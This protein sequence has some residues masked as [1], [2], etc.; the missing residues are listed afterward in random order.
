MTTPANN[1]ATGNATNKS[2]LNAPARA[3][4]RQKP[5]HW[6]E[7]IPF[8]A[9]ANPLIDQ[10]HADFL[11]IEAYFRTLLEETTAT[12]ED[13]FNKTFEPHE[14]FLFEAAT[15]PPELVQVQRENTV[16]YQRILESRFKEYE[17]SLALKLTLL[18]FGL[19]IAPL[20]PG[21][22]GVDL[23]LD[24]DFGAED[25]YIEMDPFQFLDEHTNRTY[26]DTKNRVTSTY[27]PRVRYKQELPSMKLRGGAQ[28]ADVGWEF[29]VDK[30]VA[31]RASGRRV[32]VWG[33]QGSVLTKPSSSLYLSFV[34]AVDLLL[35]V[36]QQLDYTICVEIWGVNDLDHPISRTNGMIYHGRIKS[37]E[38]D[39]IFNLLQKWFDDAESAE[40]HN[41]FVYFD[42]E[43]PPPFFQPPW[44]LDR[45]I[46]RVWN[47]VSQNMTYMKA[48]QTLDLTYKPNQYL[49]EYLRAMQVLF[50][51]A[52]HRYLQFT[53]EEE[54]GLSYG[55][56][57]PP[58]LVWD[59]VV[60]DQAENGELP[61]I[62]ISEIPLPTNCVAVW[63]PGCHTYSTEF[64]SQEP[65]KSESVFLLWRDLKP[66]GGLTSPDG[67][68][69]RPGLS[70]LLDLATAAN[71]SASSSR[72][73]VGLDV[74][75]P[76][77]RYL[78]IN[79]RPSRLNITNNEIDDQTLADWRLILH[80]F[81][82]PRI[83]TETKPLSIV[84][85]P[86]FDDYRFQARGATRRQFTMDINGVDATL[87][88][89]KAL[90]KST[91]YTEY[92]GNQKDQVL[93]LVQSTWKANL[94]EF[95]IRIDTSEEEWQAIVRRI[96]E[97]EITISLEHWTNEWVV[98]KETTWGPR[99]DLA[100]IDKLSSHYEH[101][102]KPKPF[103]GPMN[104]FFRRSDKNRD[105]AD[106]AKK[107]RDRFFWDIPSV[108]ANPAKP[109]IPIQGTPVETIIRTGPNV[110]G[111]ITAMRTPSE[112]A[113]LEREVHTLR[114]NLLQKI[115]ECP[116]MDCNRYFPF[117][118]GEGLARHMREEHQVLQCFLCSK[119][120]TL[121][122]YNS[123]GVRK[124]FLDEHYDDLKELF[125]IPR[126]SRPRATGTPYCNRC[127]RN[128]ATLK[129]AQD[130]KHHNQV[131]KVGPST[132][133]LYCMFCGDDR[134]FDEPCACGEVQRD[135]S[136]RGNFC[137]LCCLEYDSTMDLL[138]RENHRHHCKPPGGRLNDFCPDCGIILADISD[139]KKAKHTSLCGGP[140]VSPANPGP[141]GSVRTSR[142]VSSAGDP[143]PAK[144]GADGDGDG[145]DGGDG[146]G[147]GDGEGDGE[148]EAD[149]DLQ[150]TIDAVSQGPDS[151]KGGSSKGNKDQ[152]NTGKRKKTPEADVPDESTSTKRSLVLWRKATERDKIPRRRAASPR[153]H[154]LLEPEDDD[155]WPDIDWRCSRCFKA[156]GTNLDE[157]EMH[158]D[159]NRSCR[160]RRSLGTT[161]RGSMPNRSGWILPEENFDF[162][163]AYFNFVKRYPAYKHTMFPV[164][165][166]SV[167]KVWS[168][169]YDLD[170]AIGSIV[171]DPNF[172]GPD[173]VRTRSGLLPWPPYRG[174]II[175]LDDTGSSSSNEDPEGWDEKIAPLTPPGIGAGQAIRPGTSRSDISSTRLTTSGTSGATTYR[176][177]TTGGESYRS[178]TSGSSSH[179]TSGHRTSSM[180]PTSSGSRVTFD[181]QTSRPTTRGSFS[182]YRPST[183]ASSSF[184]TSSMP[185]SSARSLSTFAT[186]ASG[187]S[188][189]R[190]DRPSTGYSSRLSGSQGIEEEETGVAPL[191][192]N[193]TRSQAQVAVPL[194]PRRRAR[195][196]KVTAKER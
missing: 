17:P 51:D 163:S 46:V 140:S 181:S 27:L 139:A 114:G 110:P 41:C 124:H 80:G 91:L 170:I 109:G 106:R 171:D 131:C 31:Y 60:R 167:K 94:V 81:L 153:W 142:S 112:V 103:D 150:K 102:W 72:R 48:P 9:R 78:N 66:Q 113:R 44:K 84:V 99:Y 21:L 29:E 128:Q 116:Y 7:K 5:K 165:D 36:A 93:H 164:R 157:I 18:Y 177:T 12:I 189:G 190:S 45:Y 34:D 98:E 68:D 145:G 193:R 65:S 149:N 1:A 188:S 92:S 79:H 126:G 135:I 55:L 76:G 33:Y 85:R 20:K 175:P 77:E 154:L 61:T 107:L 59:Q 22:P 73:R 100:N 141:R 3:K 194:E 30:D 13:I 56:F 86:V 148:G 63:I 192:R 24:L 143:E 184:R 176:S 54:G 115:R 28:P 89:F 37:P 187:P 64:W 134:G 180:P 117:R 178:V 97:P 146:S 111:F 121:L 161:K 160:I 101:T 182:S 32:R 179:G 191:R 70:K 11:R 136:D 57:D 6:L 104:D 158:M 26:G 168:E 95:A 39:P 69:Y 169:P 119:Q 83:H 125:G 42:K 147:D 52:P 123:Y 14:L 74:W 133:G 196:Q 137:E 132:P 2:E 15:S 25:R 19:P 10:N 40:N 166:A 71:P 120:S 127:G 105:G 138:Y 159:K 35:G 82:G 118:D 155:I 173:F 185:P 108:F 43:T 16:R 50:P 156:A 152:K 38:N 67:F 144:P 122:F 90:V 130:Q 195:G 4:E 62:S 172:G 186:Q 151:G 47:E 174:R 87:E 49:G 23:S 58:S 53:I 129:N 75:I 88:A 8:E 162:S 96:T 183:S